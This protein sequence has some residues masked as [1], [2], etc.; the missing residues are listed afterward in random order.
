MED[1]SSSSLAQQRASTARAIMQKWASRTENTY[2]N[3]LLHRDR[4][5][6]GEGEYVEPVDVFIA[7]ASGHDT[8]MVDWAQGLKPEI[9]D[10]TQP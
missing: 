7:M 10:A 5:M 2:G 9:M 1:P 4:N 6:N 8:D 3:F